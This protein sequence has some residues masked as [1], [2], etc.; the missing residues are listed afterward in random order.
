MQT[1]PRTSTTNQELMKYVEFYSISL[2][3]LT[4][5]FKDPKD[6]ILRKYQEEIEHLRRMLENRQSTPLKIEDLTGDEPQEIN[7][8]IASENLDLDAKRDR[9]IQKYEEEMQKLKNLHENEKIEKENILKQ[10]ETI[11]KE[12]EENIERLNEQSNVQ[13]KTVSKEEILKRIEAL[14]AVMIGGEKAN[15]KELS[16]RRKK[17]KLASERR[18]RFYFEYILHRKLFKKNFFF[19]SV[20]SLMF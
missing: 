13:H 3:N 18:L 5:C 9:L 4:F 20:R 11:K 12:Y 19:F 1:E 17:K 10:I 7:K 6:A 15:D 2:Y 16:E 8:N 14:K